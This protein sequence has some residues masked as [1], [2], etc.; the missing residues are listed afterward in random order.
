MVK[1]VPTVSNVLKL[2]HL[3]SCVK[4]EAERRLNN[5]EVIGYHT[6]SDDSK[7]HWTGCSQCNDSTT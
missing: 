6:T 3:L 4:D 5:L 2:Q 7:V 1:D